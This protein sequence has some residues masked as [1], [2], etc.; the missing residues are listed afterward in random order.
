MHIGKKDYI[1]LNLKRKTVFIVPSFPNHQVCW[2]KA[3]PPVFN[4]VLSTLPSFQI[5]NLSKLGRENFYFFKKMYFP[6]YISGCDFLHP[7]PS[8]I[9]LYL[10]LSKKKKKCSNVYS[11]WCLFSYLS[12]YFFHPLT[13][14]LVRA[15]KSKRRQT[16]WQI[17]L[18]KP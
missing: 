5:P 4:D 1:A 7:S 6:V 15:G 2:P 16:H 13:I 11:H 12:L 18:L 8:I 17:H 3:R 9:F 10:I 14:I